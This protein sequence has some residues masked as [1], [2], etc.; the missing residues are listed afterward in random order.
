MVLPWRIHFHTIYDAIYNTVKLHGSL[1]PPSGPLTVVLYKHSARVDLVRTT[2][3]GAVSTIILVWG[4]QSCDSSFWTKDLQDSKTTKTMSIFFSWAFISSASS[5]I[6][7]HIV[8]FI[9]GQLCHLGPAYCIH[10]SFSWARVRYWFFPGNE[11]CLPY[12]LNSYNHTNWNTDKSTVN[13]ITSSPKKQKQNVPGG[14]QTAK[15]Q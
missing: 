3:P 5:L 6:L 14:T 9:V 2:R 11:L 15:P 8:W 10:R 4:K 12:T 7:L 1:Q 13:P